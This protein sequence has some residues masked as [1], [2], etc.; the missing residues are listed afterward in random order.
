M[1]AKSNH[2]PITLSPA[3]QP[4]ITITMRASRTERAVRLIRYGDDV[5][6]KAVN[7]AVSQSR[8]SKP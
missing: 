6:N 8:Q 5:V 4:H 1:E 2:A 7:K 3:I